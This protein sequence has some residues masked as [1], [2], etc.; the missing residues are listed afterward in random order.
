MS[1]L[2]FFDLNGEKIS[3][4]ECNRQITNLIR[5]K[6][7]AKEK[8]SEGEKNFIRQY[9]GSGGFGRNTSQDDG[10]LY[11]FYTPEWLCGKMWQKAEDFG[12]KGGKVFDPSVGTG[13]FIRFAP[14][15]KQVTGFETKD[16]S[17]RITEI[18]YPKAKV[19]LSE[20][21]TAF[22]NKDK[23]KLLPEGKVTWLEDYPFDLVIGNPPYGIFKSAYLDHFTE[24][25]FFTME[26]FFIYHS[27]RLLRPG[28]LLVFLIPSQFMQNGRK[29]NESKKMI[30]AQG[31]LL[32]AFRL[33]SVFKGSKIRTD[34]FIFKKS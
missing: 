4:A 14:D 3:R 6:D 16:L 25:R 1:R 2:T 7:N 21:E 8:Y 20:F 23:S 31:E 34:I 32:D 15:E 24:P 33:P 28:G 18:L 12:F 10:V 13:N 11:E 27:L 5:R 9:S 17:K 26:S 29:Y 19:Y 30:G 22:L